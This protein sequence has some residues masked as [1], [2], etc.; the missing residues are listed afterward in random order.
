VTAARKPR[1][2]ELRQHRDTALIREIVNAGTGTR[3]GRHKCVLSV[4]LHVS[5]SPETSNGQNMLGQNNAWSKD[6]QYVI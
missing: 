1:A 3:R 5:S 6:M 2:P 4:S